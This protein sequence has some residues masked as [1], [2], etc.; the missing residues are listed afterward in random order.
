M[1]RCFCKVVARENVIK[2]TARF[3]HCFPQ[4]LVTLLQEQDI[5]LSLKHFP[6]YLSILLYES[7]VSPAIF[8][9]IPISH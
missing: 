4:G 9:V 5:T 1:Y 6:S 2:R 8:C 7:R 3:K